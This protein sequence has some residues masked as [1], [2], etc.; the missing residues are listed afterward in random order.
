MENLEKLIILF[1]NKKGGVGKST[2]TSY[3]AHAAKN[4][5]CDACIVDFD[6]EST[7]YKQSQKLSLNVPVYL[8]DAE[9]IRNQLK[10]LDHKMIF[11]DTPPQS[12]IIINRVAMVADEV[13]IPISPTAFDLDRLKNTMNLVAEVEETRNKPLLSIL[14]TKYR[15]GVNSASDVLDLLEA[16]SKEFPLLK[17]KIRMLDRYVHYT[18]PTYLEEYEAVLKELGI[19]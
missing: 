2:S 3:A 17:S 5:G 11:V 9:N 7:L 14:I 16:D 4:N 8:G 1:A 15:V 12:E 18:E 13:I 19:I 6:P 10:D